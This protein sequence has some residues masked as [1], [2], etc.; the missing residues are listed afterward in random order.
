M[1]YLPVCRIAVQF[2]ERYFQGY[3]TKKTV[4]YPFQRGTFNELRIYQLANH[5][6]QP[7]AAYISFKIAAVINIDRTAENYNAYYKNVQTATDKAKDILRDV[8]NQT[9]HLFRVVSGDDNIEY[10]KLKAGEIVKKAVGEILQ[11]WEE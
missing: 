6:F 10:C 4:I 3:I 1:P 8:T 7:C 5:C 11:H 9:G 2:L